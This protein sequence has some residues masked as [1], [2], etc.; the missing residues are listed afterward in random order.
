M[1]GK[2][3]GDDE[4]GEGESSWYEYKVGAVE[5]LT[6]DELGRVGAVQGDGGE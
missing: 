1:K 2:L 6:K 3:D 4:A 5:E